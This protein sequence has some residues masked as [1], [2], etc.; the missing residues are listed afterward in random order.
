MLVLKFGGTSVGTAG[1]VEK[2]FAIVNDRDH[3]AKVR[4]V[5]VS[6]LSGMTDGLITAA[7]QS[8]RG[9]G[10][11]TA[12]VEALHGRHREL[13]ADLFDAGSREAAEALIGE[14][15]SELSRILDGVTILQ[16]LSPRSLDYIMSFGE[17]LSASLITLFFT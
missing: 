16:E 17:R 3:G 12:M 4:V 1:A 15:F 14:T 9:D 5:V 2:L 8:A 7:R 11:Y 13:A 6:A 10:G